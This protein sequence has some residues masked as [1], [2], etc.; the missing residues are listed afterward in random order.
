MG[1]V[2]LAYPAI[3]IEV[4]TD[5]GRFAADA[6]AETVVPIQPLSLLESVDLFVRRGQA[7]DRGF[8][9]SPTNRGQLCALVEKLDGLPLAIELAA[10][11]AYVLSPSQILDR[12]SERFKLLKGG[13]TPRQE[14]MIP[15][16][17]GL[18]DQK[19]VERSFEAQIL[20]TVVENEGVDPEIT[21]GMGSRF[22]TVLVH[23]GR[24]AVFP[25]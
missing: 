3:A 24:F 23:Q 20:K 12:L 15:K 19:K 16:G 21:D 10:A 18:V 2:G 4:A 5:P 1:Y 14:T 7:A 22:D 8:D 13:D 11:R 25:P 6:S 17:I 9:L